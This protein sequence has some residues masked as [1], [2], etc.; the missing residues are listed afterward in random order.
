M[1]EALSNTLVFVVVTLVLVV[2]TG[3]LV[4]VI[5][6]LPGTWLMLFATTGLAVWQWEEGLIG[7][8]TLLFMAVLAMLGEVVETFASA[9]G[10]KKSGSS[11]RGMVGAIVGGIIGALTGTFLI[12]VPVLGTIVGACA[13]AGFGTMVGDKWAGRNWSQIKRAGKGAAVGKFWG[14]LGKG[15]IALLMWITAVMAIF[16]P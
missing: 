13:G 1:I 9:A 12:P 5:L 11:K 15:A 4:L 8:W 10:A 14:T 6:Q 2:N 16:I 3:S 7:I